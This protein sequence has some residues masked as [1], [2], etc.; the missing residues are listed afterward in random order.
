MNFCSPEAAHPDMPHAS[1]FAD[2]PLGAP[3]LR[4]SEELKAHLRDTNITLVQYAREHGV[5]YHD[6]VRLVNGMLK[7]KYGKSADAAKR[8]GLKVAA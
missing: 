2:A 6:A 5:E 4:T 8:L 7:G 1:A 3:P